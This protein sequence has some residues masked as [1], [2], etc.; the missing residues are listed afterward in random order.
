MSK[1]N[2][3]II[4]AALTGAFVS[5]ASCPSVP[6]TPWEIAADAV[7]CA[8]AGAAIVH[9]HVRKE[10]LSPTMETK[11]FT[12]VFHAVREA[13]QR[14]NVDVIVNLTT[15]NGP[16]SDELRLAHLEELRPEMCSF[17]A[18]TFNW[19]NFV[20]ENSPS[21]L[22]KLGKKTL[23]LDIKPEIEVFDVPMIANAVRLAERGLL[24]TPC[25]FQFILGVNEGGLEGDIESVHN[26]LV[27]LPVDCTWSISGIG[28]AHMPMMLAGLAA[29]ADGVRVGLE[30]N[31]FYAK[32]VKTTNVALVER[33]AEL[34]RLAGRGIATAAEARE[35]LGI[36]RKSW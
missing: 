29:G 22:E 15:S 23:E 26:L 30:D 14:E 27:K 1:T 24:K 4:S 36:D 31:I 12:Q 5:K 19:G 13:C 32:G 10:N 25:H 34:G 6:V 2:K 7:A 9:L 17:D 33:A 35:I 8:R 16:A 28:K 11:Y 20:F 21:F 3:L 18:G